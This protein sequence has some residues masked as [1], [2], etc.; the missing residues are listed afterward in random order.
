VCR[1]ISDFVC[2]KTSTVDTQS[3]L[4]VLGPSIAARWAETLSLMLFIVVFLPS[5]TIHQ[6]QAAAQDSLP[7]IGL[8]EWRDHV[9]S[10]WRHTH[11][12]MSSLYTWICHP[13]P[14]TAWANQHLH[15][16]FDSHHLT[17]WT[18]SHGRS[19]LHCAGIIGYAGRLLKKPFRF[20]SDQKS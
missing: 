9:T 15:N 20:F 2:S 7:V 6:L 18:Q 4:L 17:A 3:L 13:S 8:N 19:V 12:S 14:G 10:P 16:L 5:S 1:P 11:R